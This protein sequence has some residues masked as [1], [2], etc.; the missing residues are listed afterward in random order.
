MYKK[1][2][3][4]LVFLFYKVATFLAKKSLNF[5][6]VSILSISLKMVCLSSSSS[7]WISLICSTAVLSS[8]TT[9]VGKLLN[10]M[11]PNKNLKK[12]E[13][14]FFSVFE[15]MK[16][17]PKHRDSDGNYIVDEWID[18]SQIGEIFN[19]KVFL[20][21]EYLE[22]ENKY[23]N[24]IKYLFNYYNCDKIQLV[25]REFFE[26]TDLEVLGKE[27]LI[28][29]YNMILK[30]SEILVSEIEITA[31]MILRGIFNV[32]LRCILNKNIAVRFGYDF[33]MNFSAFEEDK[34]PIVDYIENE[35]KL[36]TTR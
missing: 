35:I 13:D 36:F 15:V 1:T 3:N 12:R 10:K 2:S 21:D 4:L 18:S 19:G 33:Y 34:A 22:I 9:S 29:F 20:L 25:D 16:Y 30:K 27:E 26:I 31:K 8:I 17:N 14:S 24:A 11:K 6:L 28:P 23:I 32:N 7:C 5:L